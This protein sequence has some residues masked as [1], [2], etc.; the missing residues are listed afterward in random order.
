MV[1]ENAE[2]FGLNLSFRLQNL[3]QWFYNVWRPAYNQ[4]VRV[5]FFFSIECKKNFWLIFSRN[6]DVL[7]FF[8]GDNFIVPFNSIRHI[9]SL[10]LSLSVDTQY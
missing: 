10:L 9:F 6:C 2:K 3:L 4:R 7:L 8:V 1:A 5:E